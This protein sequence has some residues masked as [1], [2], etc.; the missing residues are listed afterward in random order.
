MKYI[1][2]KNRLNNLIF[3]YLDDK[4]EE[5]EQIRGGYF[6][7]FFKFPNEKYGMLGWKK[8]GNLYIHKSLINEISNLFGMNR[9]NTKEIIGKYVENT[10]NLKISYTWQG[11]Q[12][13]SFSR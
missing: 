3:K 10:Y 2:T 12:L 11:G 7:I 1:I 9:H 5:L 13:Y 6:D 4:F 8:S